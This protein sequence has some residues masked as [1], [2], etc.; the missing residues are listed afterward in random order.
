LAFALKVLLPDNIMMESLV[1]APEDKPDKLDMIPHKMDDSFKDYESAF[2]ELKDRG[3]S[4]AAIKRFSV[5]YLKGTVKFPCIL[6]DKKMY[7]WIE[8]NKKWDGRYGYQPSGVKRNFLLFGLDRHIKKAYLVESMTDSLKLIS[9]NVEAVSTCG[10]MIFKE[11]ARILIQNCDAIVLVPQNDNPAKLWI[12]QAKTHFKGKIVLTGIAINKEFK[13]IG[14]D[15][16]TKEMWIKDS[17][18]EKLIH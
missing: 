16:Y 15:G 3:I 14:S 2:K 11:Q 6:P 1:L 12:N 13:D 18:K 17:A 4:K 10:N 7:G 9:W 5:G 8:R